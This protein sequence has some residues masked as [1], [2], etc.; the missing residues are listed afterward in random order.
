MKID[1]LISVVS[2]CCI[3]IV[4]VLLTLLS[5]AGNVN[6][7]SSVTVTNMEQSIEQT[8]ERIEREIEIRGQQLQAIAKIDEIKTMDWNTQQPVLVQQANEWGFKDL[9][10]ASLD[11]NMYYAIEDAIRYQKEE[12]FYGMIIEGEP[13]ITEPYIVEA[14]GISII[15][16]T[17]PIRDNNNQ[18]LGI[19]CGT[20]VLDDISEI[21]QGYSIGQ[22]GYACI[23]N[24]A[25]EFVAHK[26]MRL[27]FNRLNL[28]DQGQNLD[29]LLTKL[30]ADE[31]GLGEYTF[32]DGD[33]RV[34]YTPLEGTPWAI[35]VVQDKG[36]NA[37]QLSSVLIRGVVVAVCLIAI[38]GVL[39]ILVVRGVVTKALKLLNIKAT[40]LAECDLTIDD[41]RYS[42]R[43]EVGHALNLFSDA[44]TVLN[45][46]MQSIVDAER[47]V[48]KNSNDIGKMMNDISNEVGMATDSV[49]NITASMEQLDASFKE[50][51]DVIHEV[52][53]NTKNSS[54]YVEQGKQVAE[55]IQAQA[56]V[57]HEN[58]LKSKN[59]IHHIYQGISEKL[60]AALK[61]AKVVDEIS[62]MS[63][64]ILEI[65]DQTTLL[66]LN[67]SIEAARAGEQ[68]KGFAVVADE[69]SK[70]ADASGRQVQVI[71]ANIAE[72]LDAVED[73]TAASGEILEILENQIMA[74]YDGMIEVAKEYKA[75]GEKVN[76]MIQNIKKSTDQVSN[77]VSCA[78]A[79]MD[80]IS[81]V[82]TH[83]VESSTEIVVSMD[84]IEK[85]NKEVHNRV[86]NNIETVSQ[87][88]DITNQFTL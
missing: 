23:I 2:I 86:N 51:N 60:N 18:L 62:N 35:M 20:I 83:I 55:S 28:V 58:T 8:A 70:L 85:Q 14:E 42:D 81:D 34:A 52:D 1:G 4:V 11:G 6:I 9:F 41:K 13:I 30:M 48:A 44:I 64:S 22:E 12:P 88:T 46:T 3:T 17:R 71:Q 27:V 49:G 84:N 26:D 69:V 82:V 87:L 50:I 7:L 68:G 77:E 54:L 80:G 72:V 66:A 63:H 31:T 37:Q 33:K 61:K 47:V 25:G 53:A 75:T 79:N 45:G 36:E 43:N 78:T 67:A 56:D 59:E 5:S 21:I 29:Q 10:V 24:D 57:I 15:T 39:M 76:E 19:L 65:A 40:R 32:N 73:L 38:C 16:M 74:D